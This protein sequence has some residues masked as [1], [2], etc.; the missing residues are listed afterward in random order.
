MERRDPLLGLGGL[1]TLLG[2]LVYG[3][4]VRPRPGLEAD[5]GASSDSARDAWLV[6]L[7]PAAFVTACGCVF[8]ALW[9]SA[10]LAA[11]E[12]PRTTSII[13]AAVALALGLQWWFDGSDSP[14]VFWAML[15]FV[16]LVPSLVVVPALATGV[17]W[18]RRRRRHV[19]RGGRCGCC[20]GGACSSS[21]PRSSSS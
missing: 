4:V 1:A 7:A 9:A 15:A 12:R 6:G 10:G 8:V 19:G 14:V 21:S 11:R 20:A 16:G 17:W 5:C 2:L 3:W 18:F 13:L